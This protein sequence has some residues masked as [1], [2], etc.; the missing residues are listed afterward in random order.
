MYYF[1]KISRNLSWIWIFQAIQWELSELILNL[2]KLLFIFFLIRVL[3]ILGF[4]EK[5]A[6]PDAK[7]ADIWYPKEPAGTSATTMW[8][9]RAGAVSSIFLEWGRWNTLCWTRKLL[10]ELDSVQGWRRV[11]ILAPAATVGRWA[12]QNT[13]RERNHKAR[14]A[15]VDAPA[16]NSK[17]I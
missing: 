7:S 4:S 11:G 13:T 15:E 5:S 6:D 3:T 2:L 10:S 9:T 16:A 17:T 8:K 12:K 1:I 14:P